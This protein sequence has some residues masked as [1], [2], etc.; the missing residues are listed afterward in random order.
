MLTRRDSDVSE[1]RARERRSQQDDDVRRYRQSFWANKIEKERNRRYLIYDLIATEFRR[2]NKR[3]NYTDSIR[4]TILNESG[5]AHQALYGCCHV[6]FVL[7]HGAF[8][9]LGRRRDGL[10]TLPGIIQCWDTQEGKLKVKFNDQHYEFIKPEHLDIVEGD[11]DEWNWNT[12]YTVSFYFRTWRRKDSRF[13]F[14]LNKSCV[15]ELKSIRSA[16][17]EAVLKMKDRI[18]TSN[19][20]NAKQ[21]EER[22]EVAATADRMR[23]AFESKQQSEQTLQIEY[24]LHGFPISHQDWSSVEQ[25][26]KL[27][28]DE[29]MEQ[30]GDGISLE[31]CFQAAIDVTSTP[32][33]KVWSDKKYMKAAISVLLHNGT[34]DIRIG[35]LSNARAH[36]AISIKVKRTI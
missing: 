29:Y 32:F 9:W 16:S 24:C 27:F 6:L 19:C 21:K 11:A 15:E 35:Y 17:A 31:Q 20:F 5:R 30:E 12:K 3:V 25:F 26:V 14:D 7:N 1:A 4:E 34:R 22:I 8:P 2:V 23:L 18:S 28:W 10:G 33:Y 13:Q 36:A